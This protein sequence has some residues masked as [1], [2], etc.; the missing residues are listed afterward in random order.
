MFCCLLSFFSHST[1][2]LYLVVWFLSSFQQAQGVWCNCK[3]SFYTSLL[4]TLLMHVHSP[5]Q[6]SISNIT[7][8]E[9]L[10]SNPNSLL[11]AIHNPQLFHFNSFLPLPWN[12]QF[13]TCANLVLMKFVLLLNTLQDI[14]VAITLYKYNMRPYVHLLLLM[15]II[16]AFLHGGFWT[17]NYLS[18]FSSF[19]DG[20]V[21]CTFVSKLDLKVF[22]SKEKLHWKKDS[23]WTFMN[24]F[25]ICFCDL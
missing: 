12:L 19:M 7:I 1:C 21:I 2:V 25:V 18:C 23:F 24:G 15:W 10:L 20:C 14:I 4:L 6:I 17:L 3:L 16:E 9:S 11:L 8:Y 13:Q 22:L 5:S